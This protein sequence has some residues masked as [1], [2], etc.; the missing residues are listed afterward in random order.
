MSGQ[1]AK[2]A[3]WPRP[4]QSTNLLAVVHDAVAA[5]DH[6][7]GRAGNAVAPRV[8]GPAGIAVSGPVPGMNVVVGSHGVPGQPLRAGIDGSCRI[9]RPDMETRIRLGLV[10]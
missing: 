9:M 1:A 6:T 8:V 4:R 7:T 2:S 10:D 3:T 5:L